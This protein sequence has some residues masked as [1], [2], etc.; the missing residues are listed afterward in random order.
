MLSDLRHLVL[1]SVLSLECSSGYFDNDYVRGILACQSGGYP[2]LS[3]RILLTDIM[4][5]NPNH[6][7][8]PL[9][10]PSLLATFFPFQGISLHCETQDCVIY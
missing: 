7:P 10:L 5:P 2:W 8:I 1:F 6:L 9:Y 3:V 4:F